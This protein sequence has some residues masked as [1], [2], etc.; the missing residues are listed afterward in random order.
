MSPVSKFRAE[1]STKCSVKGSGFRISRSSFSSWEGLQ[2]SLGNRQVCRQMEQRCLGSQ[3][4]LQIENHRASLSH[5]VGAPLT[6]CFEPLRS[7]RN[8][9]HDWSSARHLVRV[10]FMWLGPLGPTSAPQKTLCR[11]C[12]TVANA[13]DKDTPRIKDLRTLAKITRHLKQSI[14]ICNKHEA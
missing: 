13:P 14:R 3:F 4:I 9:K 7:P 10:S 1:I 2:P 8:A 11:T 6:L 12:R 5:S